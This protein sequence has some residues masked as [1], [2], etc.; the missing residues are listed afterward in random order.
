MSVSAHLHTQRHMAV[1]I[2][3]EGALGIELAKWEQHRTKYVGDEQQPGN[4][5]VYREYPRMLFRAQRHPV[6]GKTS[7]AEMPP[8]SIEFLNQN[9]FERAD[10]AVASFNRSCQKTVE[11]ADEYRIAMN[12]GWRESPVDAIAEYEKRRKGTSDIAANRHYND[13]FMS[14]AA[15]AEAAAADAGTDE[16]LA[17]IPRTP[18]KRR[19]RKPRAE[20]APVA[21]T[22]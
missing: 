5:Y 3:H 2:N 13:Q 1:Q 7:C 4:P 11:S 12:D 15:R 19:G 9:E 22:E 18:I 21:V 8:N 14:P 16:H 10:R 20:A 17:E 6:T